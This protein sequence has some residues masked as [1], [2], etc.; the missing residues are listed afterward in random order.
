MYGII[1]KKK[2]FQC[3]S[4]DNLNKPNAETRTSLFPELPITI[5]LFAKVIAIAKPILEAEI[6]IAAIHSLPVSNLSATFKNLALFP[7]IF[8]VKLP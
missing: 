5:L 7:A 2:K 6:D 8:E 3:N 1:Q 4:T